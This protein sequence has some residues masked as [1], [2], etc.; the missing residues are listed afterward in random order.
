MNKPR[1]LRKVNANLYEED[2]REGGKPFKWHK[3]YE[4]LKLNL[5]DVKIR[6]GFEMSYKGI[7]SLVDEDSTCRPRYLQSV[8][9]ITNG[10]VFL[11]NPVESEPKRF[12][13]VRLTMRPVAVE[14]W[15]AVLNERRKAGYGPGVFSHIA[16]DQIEYYDEKTPHLALEL[17][18]PED[19]YDSIVDKI[20]RV[21]SFRQKSIEL[22][23]E[24]AFFRSEVDRGL[25][26]YYHPKDY[27]IEHSSHNPAYF[28]YLVI[29]PEPT[30]VKSN[31]PSPDL[32]EEKVLEPSTQTGDQVTTALLRKLSKQAGWIIT[33]LSFIAVLMIFH[34]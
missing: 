23:A 12:N 18:I 19:I 29:E 11:I 28:S 7:G 22:S 4:L 21:R 34:R 24:I 2:W 5:N 9:E 1:N 20:E 33:L 6:E 13:S 17:T 26:E 15:A 10:T 32:D 25:E 3:K 8:G 16:G 14:G 30:F 27:Y 31:E